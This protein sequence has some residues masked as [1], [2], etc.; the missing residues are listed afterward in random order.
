MIN[1]R[2]GCSFFP[3]VASATHKMPS[4][5]LTKED[6][7][8]FPDV[9]DDIKS[10]LQDLYR[11]SATHAELIT[12][13]FL[14]CLVLKARPEDPSSFSMPRLLDYAWHEAILNT[15]SYIDM[16]QSLFGK[17]VHHTTTTTKD[18][19]EEKVARIKKMLEYFKLYWGED[20][21]QCPTIWKLDEEGGDE[22]K[23]NSL[24]E[25]SL[26]PNAKR[27]RK[28]QPDKENIT[29]RFIDS[30]GVIEII[31]RISLDTDLQIAKKAFCCKTG[32]SL[33]NHRLLFDG[34]RVEPGDTPRSLEM[35]DGD[36]VSAIFFQSGC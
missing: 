34:L 26:L 14:R 1:I 5:L 35:K 7:E 31:F 4:A 18:P 11:W 19:K 20:P 16:C 12:L 22:S 27:R 30:E 15:E 2:G 8:K 36:I 3:T 24:S 17:I 23:S 10:R 6:L 29:I 33:G 25:D 28:E 32:G 21:Y 13:D 9:V